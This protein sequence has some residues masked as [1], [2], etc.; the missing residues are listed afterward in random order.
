MLPKGKE[1]AMTPLTPSK[2]PAI[3]RAGEDVR[4]TRWALWMVPGFAAV[5]F[6][7]SLVG[8]YL[9]FPLLGLNEG[10]IFLFARDAAGWAVSVVG[11]LLLACAPVAG[12]VLASRALRHGGR[13]G[14]W[15]A[16]VLNAVLLLLTAYIAFDE[17]RMT[18][19]PTMTFP[20]PA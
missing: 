11:W 13:A 2:G 15:I 8:L 7:T 17:I 6:A 10:D 1:E 12:L 3:A 18:Y 20:L 16:L 4:L 19:F 9:V 5:Y 14:A